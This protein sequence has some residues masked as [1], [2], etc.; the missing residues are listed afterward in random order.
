MGYKVLWVDNLAKVLVV[1]VNQV[2]VA[3]E[4]VVVHNLVYK[5]TR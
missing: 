2:E 5:T 3:F 1:G 4:P